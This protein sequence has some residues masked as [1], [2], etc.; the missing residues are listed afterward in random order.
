[1]KNGPEMAMVHSG[2]GIT[3][4]HVPSD[5]IIDASMPAMIRTSGMMWN[6]EGNLQRSNFVRSTVLLTRLPWEPFLM[7]V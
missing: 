2:K 6:G 1:M 3:N 5:V 4:L 7:L